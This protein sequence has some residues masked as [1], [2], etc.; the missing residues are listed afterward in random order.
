[1]SKTCQWF[2][3]GST[4]CSCTWE[5]VRVG[6]IVEFTGVD[7]ILYNG[8]WDGA[9]KAWSRAWCWDSCSLLSH[10]DELYPSLTEWAEGAYTS[11]GVCL[12]LH[13]LK[14]SYMLRNT[15]TCSIFCWIWEKWIV[16]SSAVEYVGVMWVEVC[17]SQYE[18]FLGIWQT[19]S[20]FAQIKARPPCWC[21]ERRPMLERVSL[22][23]SHSL[24]L[25]VLYLKRLTKVLS[26]VEVCCPLLVL[27]HQHLCA[28]CFSFKL[29]FSVT[30]SHSTLLSQSL[31]SF[32]N[33]LVLKWV[34]VEKLKKK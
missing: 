3:R 17:Y 13:S 28:M 21:S 14:D 6:E 4:C 19:P 30:F 12:P 1:M 18:D 9:W 16:F 20:L 22:F 27:F 2:P 29:Y 8:E 26:D 11:V 7:K 5:W 23:S 33:V 32:R 31:V 10:A 24:S 15:T 34:W 25:F